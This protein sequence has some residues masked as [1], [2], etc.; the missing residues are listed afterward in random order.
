[1][2]E[3]KVEPYYRRE[4]KELVELLFDKRFLN[5]DLS[6]EA[7]DWLEDYL[8]FIL[9]IKVNGAVKCALLTAEFRESNLP[10]EEK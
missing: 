1:M 4:G 3:T 7:I 5:D 9:Q 10:K 6:K 2:S 8:G